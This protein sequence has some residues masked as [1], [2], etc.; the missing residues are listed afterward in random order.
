[1]R[2]TIKTLRDENIV[3]RTEIDEKDKVIEELAEFYM[4]CEILSINLINFSTAKR[5]MCKSIQIISYYQIVKEVRKCPSLFK[6]SVYVIIL[7][8]KI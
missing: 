3:M 6:S 4:V 8:K 1:M 5:I 7:I 2:E